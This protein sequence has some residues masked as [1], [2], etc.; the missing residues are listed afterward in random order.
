MK[1]RV[2]GRKGLE[3][4]EMDVT[5]MDFEDGSFDVIL[6]KVFCTWYL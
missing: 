6:D 2:G 3:Y 4:M 1:K 5:K